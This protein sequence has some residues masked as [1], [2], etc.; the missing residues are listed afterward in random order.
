M[1]TSVLK[2]YT[3]KLFVSSNFNVVFLL[4]YQFQDLAWF[5][6]MLLIAQ[7]VFIFLLLVGTL[8]VVNFIYQKRMDS[9]RQYLHGF[10]LFVVNLLFPFIVLII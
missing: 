6:S 9:K 5:K 10:L 7:K 1:I 8:F 4:L 2:I 3:I